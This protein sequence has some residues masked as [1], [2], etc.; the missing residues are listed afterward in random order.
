MQAAIEAT[1]SCLPQ[2][3]PC[4]A[5]LQEAGSDG[6][7]KDKKSKGAGGD[8]ANDGKGG[9]DK[10]VTEKK[11]AAVSAETWGEVGDTGVPKEYTK[12]A[13]QRSFLEGATKDSTLFAGC[14]DDG[15]KKLI[16]SMFERKCMADEVIIAQGD[17]GDNFYVAQSGTYSVTLKQKGVTPVHFYKMGD[18]FGELALMYNTPRAATVKCVSDGTLWALDRIAF[19]SIL[20]TVN[21]SAAQETAQ[22]SYTPRTPHVLLIMMACELGCYGAMAT[23]AGSCRERSR[24][25]HY[26]VVS[27]A[28]S[29]ASIS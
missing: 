25:R 26:A 17:P 21:K 3:K 14:T 13:E 2:L 18:T 4:L 23:A 20:M 16:D 12:T 9:G 27:A 8:K 15:R 10:K 5:S 11:R 6:V 22:V 19:R 28:V 24:R 29:A 1:A 7:S